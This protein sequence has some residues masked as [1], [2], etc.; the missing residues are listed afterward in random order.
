MPVTSTILCA[1]LLS[2]SAGTLDAADLSNAKCP[3]SA[4]PVSEDAS[5]K[6][7]NADLYFCCNNCPKAFAKDEAKFATKANYQL[8]ASG[9]YKQ[10][11]CPFS[12]RKL[13]P[14][15]AIKLVNVPVTFCCNNCKNKANDAEGE[16]QLELVFSEAAFAKG[17]EKA[18]AQGAE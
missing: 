3:V 1:F 10:K 9:Q 15:T 11:A 17:F 4:Q 5:V 2:V 13:N 8:V 7:K 12:G 16:A 14:A 6:Y 18:K